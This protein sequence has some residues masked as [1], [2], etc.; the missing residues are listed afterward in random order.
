MW[1]ISLK[2]AY[3]NFE[4]ELKGLFEL[5]PFLHIKC[6]WCFKRIFGRKIVK[7]FPESKRKNHESFAIVGLTIYEHWFLFSKKSNQP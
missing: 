7:L 6:L 5:A 3:L 1:T 2:W 4:G